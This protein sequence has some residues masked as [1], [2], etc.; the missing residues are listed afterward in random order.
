VSVKPGQA[1]KEPVDR[2]KLVAI[3]ELSTQMVGYIDLVHS[4]KRR[5]PSLD[6]LTPIG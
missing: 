5:H 6:M 2:T 4:H 1:P 3:V